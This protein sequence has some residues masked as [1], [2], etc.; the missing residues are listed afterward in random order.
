MLDSNAFAE[1]THPIPT[2]HLV[3]IGL[4]LLIALII[5]GL[6]GI[7]R[8][9]THKPAGLRTHMLLALGT[10][11]FVVVADEVGMSKSDLSRIVQ[12]LVTGIGFLGGGAILKLTAEHEI[13]GLTTAAGLWVTAALA[14]A[15]GIGQLLLAIMGAVIGLVVLQAFV[16]LER[17]LGHHASNDA[18]NRPPPNPPGKAGEEGG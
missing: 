1:L 13:H 5:G 12:G 4:R 17:R 2:D 8:E 10:A 7:Q 6:V 16:K 18:T 11:L 14:A 9:L 3:R 15:A